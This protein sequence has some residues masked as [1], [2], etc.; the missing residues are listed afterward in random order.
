VRGTRARVPRSNCNNLAQTHRIKQPETEAEGRE[1]SL[2]HFHAR[3]G[4]AQFSRAPQQSF[5]RVLQLEGLRR[6]RGSPAVPR[7]RVQRALHAKTP[8]LEG[9]NLSAWGKFLLH[10]GNPATHPKMRR[11]SQHSCRHACHHAGLDTYG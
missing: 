9:K 1:T 11:Q 8:L 3:V 5:R 4:V 7:H 2:P 6:P 10:Q